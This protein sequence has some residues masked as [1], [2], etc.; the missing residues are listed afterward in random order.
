MSNQPQTTVEKFTGLCETRRAQARNANISTLDHETIHLDD[1]NVASL[2]NALCKNTY[3]GQMLSLN[4][5]QLTG[6]VSGLDRLFKFI[7]NSSSNSIREVRL[8]G[9][10]SNYQS[11]ALHSLVKRFLVAIQKRNNLERLTLHQLGLDADSFYRLVRQSHTLTH[12]NL[13]ACYISEESPHN[14]EK[15]GEAFS[16]HRSL[17]SLRLVELR[18]DL[19]NAILLPL[20]AHA[21]QLRKLDVSYG[22][23]ASA[24]AIGEVLGSSQTPALRH[25]VLRNSSLIH[26]ESIV[27][28]MGTIQKLEIRNCDLD[29]VSAALLRSLFCRSCVKSRTASTTIKVNIEEVSLYDLDIDDETNLVDILDGLARSTTIK[30]LRMHHVGSDRM[31][32]PRSATVDALLKMLK[33]NQHLQEVNLDRNLLA[34]LGWISDEADTTCSADPAPSTNALVKLVFSRRTGTTALRSFFPRNSG[35]RPM[36]HKK[37]CTL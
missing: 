32:L 28:N 4:I 30:R 14:L 36:F 24:E 26:L 2:V 10:D 15:V 5:S 31:R 9:S 3:R 6:H 7:E 1:A 27:R 8:F 37:S 13:R 20:K 12:L 17:I 34:D 16:C 25:L 33:A 35:H 29:S 18:E 22:S 19:L 21:P 11:S 23:A